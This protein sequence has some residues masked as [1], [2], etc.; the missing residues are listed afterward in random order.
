MEEDRH[1]T[2]SVPNPIN[3]PTPNQNINLP[4]NPNKELPLTQAIIGIIKSAVPATFGILFVFLLETINIIFIGK[5]NDEI[6]ISGIGIGT[7]YVNATGYM[8]GFGLIGGL[9]TLCSQSHGATEY[10]T[11]GIY[12]NITRLVVFV[13]FLVICIPSVFFSSDILYSMGQLPTVVPIAEEFIHVMLPALFFALQYQNSLRYLQ[14]MNI[15]LPGMFVTLVTAALHP[16][17]CYICIFQME[18]GVAGAAIALG[19]SQ[20]LN[21]AI[22]SIYIHVTNPQPESYFLYHPDI[23]DWGHIKNFLSKGVPAAILFAADWIGFEIITFMS[24]Y[25]NEIDLAANICLFNF[26]TVIFMIPN[27]LSIAS[28]TLVGNSIG[29]ENAVKAKTYTKAV[30]IVDIAI[31]APLTILVVIFMGEIPLLYTTD[32]KVVAQIIMLLNIYKYFSIVDSIQVVLNGVIK[33]LGYQKIASVIV[34]VILYPFNITL[35]WYLGFKLNYGISGLWHAQMTSIYI[36]ATC[37]ITIVCT[38]DWDHVTKTEVANIKMF[39]D[40]QTKEVKNK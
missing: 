31:I 24:T 10:K 29:E 9:D 40:K 22:I 30:I 4:T 35:A 39:K 28:T 32:E 7:L 3:T 18:W 34:L 27:G 38:L 15:F 36:L 6:L 37:F 2:K 25:L 19:F 23:F 33:G 12:A 20:F 11:L 13:Y 14:A 5:Y 21:L 17:W 8:L 26:I 1:K 16:L